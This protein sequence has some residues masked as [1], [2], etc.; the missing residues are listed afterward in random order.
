MGWCTGVV[1]HSKALSHKSNSTRH[2]VLM[3]QRN[4]AQEGAQKPVVQRAWRK[5][6]V[7]D[8]ERRREVRASRQ[9]Q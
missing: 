9:I 3:L 8:G 1:R 4:D 6:R 5:P 7:E 2:M